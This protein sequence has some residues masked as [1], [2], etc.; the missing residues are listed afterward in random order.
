M[1]YKTSGKTTL[2]TIENA[3]GLSVS[4]THTYSNV[5]PLSGNGVTDTSHGHSHIISNWL[6]RNIENNK[7]TGTHKLETLNLG[8]SFPPLEL[9]GVDEETSEEDIDT[10]SEEVEVRL[11]RSYDEPEVTPITEMPFF[12]ATQVVN[13]TLNNSSIGTPTKFDFYREVANQ[14]GYEFDIT[15][16]EYTFLN[17]NSEQYYFNIDTE[18]VELLTNNT[19]SNLDY[20]SFYLKALFDYNFLSKKYEEGITTVSER[21]LPNQYGLIL[22][23]LANDSEIEISDW[24]NSAYRDLG[25]SVSPSK[26]EKTANDV[27]ETYNERLTNIILQTWAL[28]KEAALTSLYPT[29]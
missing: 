27:F 5:D 19:K 2:A 12:K 11:D 4:H 22:T 20:S 21:L 3:D 9:I 8:A 7:H 23:T 29:T 26:N 15:G 17:N 25:L 1:S 16:P 10:P 28:I 24:L 18:N 14:H 6:V 13:I